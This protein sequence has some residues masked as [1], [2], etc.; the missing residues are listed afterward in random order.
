M[1]LAELKQAPERALI[2]VVGPPGAGE[3]TFCQRVILNSVV[4]DKPVL[5]VTIEKGASD[6]VALLSE[7][8]PGEPTS[9][10]LVFVDAFA[11]TVGLAA[12]DRPTLGSDV[13]L[14]LAS[15]GFGFPYLVQAGG[16]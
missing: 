7:K 13:H 8:G 12:P 2:V 3:S 4:E 15:H 5:F 1:S 11:D 6:V 9:G 14:R 10:D 16:R